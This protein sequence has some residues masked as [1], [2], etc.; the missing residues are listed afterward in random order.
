MD[1]NLD[2]YPERRHEMQER[3][4]RRTVP[5]IFFNDHHIGGFDDLKKLVKKKLLHTHCTSFKKACHLKKTVNI[6]NFETIEA[7]VD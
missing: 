6:I 7:S 4:G 2:K 5:Q 1:V 3:T